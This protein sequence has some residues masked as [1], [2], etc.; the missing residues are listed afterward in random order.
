MKYAQSAF[1]HVWLSY[2]FCAFLQLLMPLLEV[3]PSIREAASVASREAAVSVARHRM[4]L[5]AAKL[6]TR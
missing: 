3:S 4:L 1:R 6:L 5:L 2:K